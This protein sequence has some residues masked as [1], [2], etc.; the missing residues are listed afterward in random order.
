MQVFGHLVALKFEYASG[1]H[2]SLEPSAI[3][4]LTRISGHSQGLSWEQF[5]WIKLPEGFSILNKGFRPMAGRQSWAS[6]DEKGLCFH[7]NDSQNLHSSVTLSSAE[8][9]N[10]L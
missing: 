7:V 8:L 9:E 3:R 4:L 5:R 1:T 6:I 2:Y 10:W